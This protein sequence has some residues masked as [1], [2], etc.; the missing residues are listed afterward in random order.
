MNTKLEIHFHISGAPAAEKVSSM[1]QNTCRQAGPP[2]PEGERPTTHCLFLMDDA[3]ETILTGDLPK[4]GRNNPALYVTDIGQMYR[5]LKEQGLPVVGYLHGENSPEDFSGAMYLI[6]DPQEVDEDSW[7]KIYQRLTGQPWTI[8]L[9]QRLLI[10]EMTPEDLD[11]L[12]ELYDDAEARRFLGTL[13]G[14]RAQEAE[15]LKSYIEKIYGLYGYGMWAVCDGKSGE[16]IG[17]AGLSPY[18]G[19]GKAQELGYLIRGDRRRQGL[20]AEAVSAVLTFAKES[21]GLETIGAR[22][23]PD[24]AASIALLQKLGFERKELLCGSSANRFGA[25]EIR[26]AEVDDSAEP[27]ILYFEKIL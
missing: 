7:I 12:Y 2:V 21:I 18:E 13:S 20:A 4:E 22:T 10:R 16:L 11:A 9:T 8:A 6:E 1:L 27:G 19:N 15:I 14:N 24:N 3:E 5:A 26:T 25:G 17:R 23:A